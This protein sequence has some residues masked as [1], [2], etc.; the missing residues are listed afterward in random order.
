MKGRYKDTAYTF[1]RAAYDEQLEAERATNT[2]WQLR[3]LTGPQKGVYTLLIEVRTLYLPPT[4]TPV[5][6][7]Q[8]TWPDAEGRSFEAFIYQ[9][10]H[11]VA[12][13]C[14]QWYEGRPTHM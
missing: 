1:T 7:Y 3:L 5:V 13:M 8:N 14:E 4:A 2:A 6:L 11:R 9:C 12:R 10:C